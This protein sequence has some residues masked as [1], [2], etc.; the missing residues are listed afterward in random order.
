LSVGVPMKFET[1][2]SDIIP[3][4]HNV[5]SFRFPRPEDLK[6]KAG[7][8]MFITIKSGDEEMR[9]H[10]TISS[11]PTEKAH[12]EF[13]KKL[14]GSDFSNALDATKIGDWAVIDAPY[15]KFT[16][17]GEYPKIGMLSGGI[18][19]T[20]LRSICRYCTDKQLET[21]ITLLYGNLTERD[22]AFR[23]E[24]TEMQEGNR[25]LKVVFTLDQPT[26][27]WSGYKGYIDVQ[28]VKKEIP[29]YMDGVFYVCGPPGMTRAMENLLRDLNL[30]KAQIK[31][32]IFT[33]Y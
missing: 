15:G 2:V 26:E 25:N 21:K 29:D 23:K 14:T 6:Y 32:E 3:R 7:Q 30:P 11:S 22:I 4:T 12:I 5:K 9:K 10:F 16:F 19:I 8:F 27:D 31:R 24:L 17:E 18:G 20:P 1:T 33:G 28:M 13:T